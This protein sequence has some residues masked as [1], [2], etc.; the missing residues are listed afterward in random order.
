MSSPSTPPRA[1]TPEQSGA[2][3]ALYR[4]A[5][6]SPLKGASSR[7]ALAEENAR[8]RY[9]AAQAGIELERNYVQMQLMNQEMTRLRNQIHAKKSKQK[10]SYT[11]T[12][13]R[14][15]TGSEMIAALL[16]DNHVKSMKTMTKEMAPKFRAIKKLLTKHKAVVS[17][18]DN[19]DGNPSGRTDLE[20]VR[21]RGRGR[22]RGRAR[23]PGRGR[24]RGGRGRGQS[25]GTAAES[26]GEG[27]V[28]PGPTRGRGR[29]VPTRPGRGRGRGGGTARGSGRSESEDDEELE[30]DEDE[31]E[32]GSAPGGPSSDS[33]SDE[34]PRSGSRSPEFPLGLIDDAELEEPEGDEIEI[35]TFNGHCWEKGNVELQ[36]VWTDKDVTWEPLANINDC[37]AMDVYLAL[38]SVADPLQLGKRKFVIEKGL[39]ARN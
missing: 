24:A 29:A 18:P 35:V 21:G 5:L 1:T 32:P 9:I 2:V 36:V 26:D 8:I 16:H 38:H 7:R 22:G 10:R 19:Y 6:P 39:K 30:E 11:T 14:L 15:L 3:Q 27:K 33:S 37:A 13:A 34:S 23:G 20:P 28:A 4:L 12:Q 31:S 17:G 25:S